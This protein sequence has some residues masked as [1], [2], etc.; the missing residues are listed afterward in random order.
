MHPPGQALLQSSSKNLSGQAPLQSSSGNPHLVQL[1]YWTSPVQKPEASTKKR[2]KSTLN[3]DNQPKLDEIFKRKKPNPCHEAPQPSHTVENKL[4]TSISRPREPSIGVGVEGSA[5]KSTESP[6]T[7]VRSHKDGPKP[8]NIQ[9][10]VEKAAKGVP[11]KKTIFIDGAPESIYA[12]HN[13]MSEKKNLGL[14]FVRKFSESIDAYIVDWK[15]PNSNDV[16]KTAYYYQCLGLGIPVL[17]GA[18]IRWLE[19]GG[20]MKDEVKNCKNL[21]VIRLSVLSVLCS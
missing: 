4:Y 14:E 20:K 15:T 10:Y 3:P 13:A 21:I 18:Y 8:F 19:H 9:D 6:P 7:G 17:S 2:S 11:R 1:P 16:L 5:T 12:K